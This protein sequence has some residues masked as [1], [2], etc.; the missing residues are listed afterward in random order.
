MRFRLANL[1]Y[2]TAVVAIIFCAW[3][4]LVRGNVAAIQFESR[5]ARV[6]MSDGWHRWAEQSYYDDETG[7]LVDPLT[8]DPWYDATMEHNV[9]LS[10]WEIATFI[11]L[12]LVLDVAIHVLIWERRRRLRFVAATANPR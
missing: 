2:L 1:L 12:W 4:W 5:G 11:G 3:H 6:W 10:F 7:Q 8:D 9:Y